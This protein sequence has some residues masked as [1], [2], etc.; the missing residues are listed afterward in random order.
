MRKKLLL[1]LL[2]LTIIIPF[3]V[4]SNGN[5]IYVVKIN[6][7]ING[8]TVSYVKDSI[9]KAEKNNVKNIIFE[10][11]TYGGQIVA[12]EKIKNLIIDTDIHSIAY[13]NNKAESAGVLITIACEK[14]YMAPTATIGSAE[15]IPKTEKNMSFWKA[16]LR[17]TAKLRGRNTQIVEAMAD[18][19]INIPGIAAKGKLLNLTAHEALDLGISN[20]TVR[21]LKD[22]LT[23]ENLEG[24]E[25]EN[26]NRTLMTKIVQ[27]TS[28]NIVS[29]L[30]LIIGM[31]CF[32]IE[33]FT[34]GF[35]IAGT[36]SIIAFALFFMGNIISGNSDFYAL[37]IFLLGIL[38]LF[39]EIIVP[40]FGLPGISGIILTIVGL[41]MSMST[42]ETALS[43]VALALI[44]SIALGIFL[45]KKGAHSKFAKNITLFASESTDR[46]FVSV[47][48]ADIN[49]NDTGVTITPLRP[50]GKA[51]IN[52]KPYEV[53]SEYGLI[54]KDRKIIVTK[55]ENAKIIVKEA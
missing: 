19:D 11:D 27:I 45:I 25:I 7:E 49:V 29:T 39:V 34:P 42:V 40:G 38:L 21:D 41:V 17:D 18:S 52:N 6:G 5:K 10:I 37:F 20:G 44:I 32:V 1:F 9:E 3:G 54:E 14:I 28:N 30:L 53:F 2:L 55:V 46:G 50:I 13:V 36:V 12:A 48:F 51:I 33:I 43:S 15:T 35:G 23:K 8:A 26:I 4:F 31:S 47:D 22:I 16:V 24:Y